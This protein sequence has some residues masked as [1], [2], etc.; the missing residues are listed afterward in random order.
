MGVKGRP[1]VTRS[2]EARR[3]K[4]HTGDGPCQREIPLQRGSLPSSPAPAPSSALFGAPGA[5]VQEE[6]MLSEPMT[7]ED[8][9]ECGRRRNP[10]KNELPAREGGLVF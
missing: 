4:F 9:Q 2:C 8:G 5:Y 7:Q 6:K 3:A 10:L 1:I